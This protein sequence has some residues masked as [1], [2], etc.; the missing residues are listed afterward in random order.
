ME[1]PHGDRARG[2]EVPRSKLIHALRASTDLITT[3]EFRDTDLCVEHEFP[4]DV[5]QNE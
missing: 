3:E 5:G 4:V 2:T 1:G